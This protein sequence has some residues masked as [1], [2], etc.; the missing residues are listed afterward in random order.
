ME[1]V[2]DECDECE[3]IICRADIED[4]SD[5]DSA[6]DHR[7][8]PCGHAQW[9]AECILTWL[10]G[11]NTCPICRAEVPDS[12][13]L[14]ESL[15][16]R[17]QVVV[18]AYL[19]EQRQT[20]QT[21]VHVIEGE[22]LAFR[23]QLEQ[24]HSEHAELCDAIQRL[25]LH[26][27]EAR[28][29][30]ERMRLH[31]E[32]AELCEAMRGLRRRQ[33]ASEA[34]DPLEALRALAAPEQSQPREQSADDAKAL[35]DRLRGAVLRLPCT[36]TQVFQT[37]AAPGA[38]KLG[39]GEVERVLSGLEARVTHAVVSEAFSQLD[40]DN[41]GFVEE[42]DWLTALRLPRVDALVHSS[43]R[44]HRALI[45]SLSRRALSS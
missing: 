2:T 34:R 9:H 37:L 24:L 5:D 29:S 17:R 40:T 6:E 45:L 33:E 38:G 3:C 39:I 11:Q 25:Q 44:R 16:A 14:N 28:L 19:E 22:L 20:L 15:S 12:H 31:L 7:G 35:L 26:Q 18:E 8:L 1:E 36:A 4:N 27:E 23:S 32:H 41:S 21:Q 43:R 10:S 13:P 42:E 30:A